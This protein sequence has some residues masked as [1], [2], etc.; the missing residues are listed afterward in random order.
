MCARNW[1]LRFFDPL[2]LLVVIGVA[3]WLFSQSGPPPVHFS[4]LKPKYAT[5][6]SLET[7][8]AAMGQDPA[9]AVEPDT[10]RTR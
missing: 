3:L 5:G 8:I 6:P 2:W 9:E 7:A 10:A 1:L 4:Q